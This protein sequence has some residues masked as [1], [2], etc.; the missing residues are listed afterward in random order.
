MTCFF[1]M[2]ASRRW[3]PVKRKRSIIMTT[4]AIITGRLARDPET[5][6]PVST[7]GTDLRL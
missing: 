6:S 5:L 7:Y 2:S 3:S 1:W 4:I